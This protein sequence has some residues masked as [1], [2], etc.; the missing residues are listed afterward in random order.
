MLLAVCWPTELNFV[1]KRDFLR[2]NREGSFVFFKSSLALA[3]N[4]DNINTTRES[5]LAR[6]GVVHHSSKESGMCVKINFYHARRHRRTD[7]YMVYSN[8]S[9]KLVSCT[10]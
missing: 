1:L 6:V 5:K 7:L 9:L 3:T 10:R 4:K 2:V 8:V